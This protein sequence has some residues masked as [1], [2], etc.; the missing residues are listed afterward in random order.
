MSLDRDVR[1]DAGTPYWIGLLNP[2]GSAG[3]LRWRDRVDYLWTAERVSQS[4]TLTALPA[5][6]ESGASWWD[7]PLSASAWGVR[8][9]DADAHSDADPD[10]DAQRDSDAD[11]V[12]A[13]AASPGPLTPDRSGRA[14]SG[15][16][17]ELRRPGA[18]R[19]ASAAR[20]SS[21]AATA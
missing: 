21:T 15:R 2:V 1:L 20:S 13:H 12:A 17:V 4:T 7:G 6:W 16:R 19:A 11:T 10:A 9:G 18:S 8:R 5:Q 3:T 14:R